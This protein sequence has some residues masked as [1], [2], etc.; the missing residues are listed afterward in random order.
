MKG[1]QDM[2]LYKPLTPSLR[3]RVQVNYSQYLTTGKPLKFLLS[4]QGK[5]GGRN[6]SGRLTAFR[7]GGGA[8][9]RYRILSTRTAQKFLPYS[10]LQSIEYD[11]FRSAFIGC[12]YLR[13]TGSFQYILAPQNPRVGGLLFS[14]YVL[15]RPNDGS[16]CLLFYSQIGDLLYNVN[17]CQGPKA[18]R[19][20]TAA[21]TFCKVI[22]KEVRDFFAVIRIPS[23]SVRRVSLGALGF[24]GK[25]SNPNHKFRMLGK[26]GRSRW[27]G[28]R[29]STRG[30][31]MNPIDHPH[32]GGE[33]KSSGGRPSCTPWGYPTRGKPTRR[34][35]VSQHILQ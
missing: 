4:G 31:A 30:V 2:K 14:N 28:R 25:V 21:G 17:L 16:A 18:Y 33:G 22:K 13:E 5:H 27:L 23:G 26:A 19:V 12:C 10:V 9:Q 29:P 6:S 24:L 32:G 7:Q 11:P 3:Q 8:A 34:S 1:Q 15:R 35:R 20:A